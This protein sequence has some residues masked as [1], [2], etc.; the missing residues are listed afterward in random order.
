MTGEEKNKIRTI[1]NATT[2][3]KIVVE[4]MYNFLIL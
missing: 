2:T 4:E 3:T 1:N